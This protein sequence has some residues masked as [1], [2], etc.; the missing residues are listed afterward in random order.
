MCIIIAKPEGVAF[1]SL[2]TLQ[3]C[4]TNND[5]GCGIAYHKKGGDTVHIKKDFPTV[6]DMWDYLVTNVGAEDSALIHFRLATSGLVDY[7]NRHPFPITQKDELLRSPDLVTDLAVA[8]NGV[9]SRWNN[10]QGELSDT[11]LFIKNVLA[12][13]LIRANLEGNIAVQT[14]L[15]DFI[16]GS[17]LAILDNAGNVSVWGHF[18]K[19]EGLYYS[20]S[21]YLDAKVTYSSL[22]QQWAEYEHQPHFNFREDTPFGGYLSERLGDTCESCYEAFSVNIVRIDDQQWLVCRNCEDQIIQTYDQC[23]CGNYTDYIDEGVVAQCI[24]CEEAI[25]LAKAS[26]LADELINDIE[27]TD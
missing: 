19:D 14:L 25:E 27:S 20:N 7:G 17:K 3:I 6:E 26:E 22:N 13:E 16:G 21:S 10:K 9:F 12:D 18:V 8:H 2:E 24:E 15:S 1:P 11:Q 4:N 5:D 23:Q